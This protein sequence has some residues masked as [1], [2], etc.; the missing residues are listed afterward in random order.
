MQQ[1]RGE[2]CRLELG[3]RTRGPERAV[4]RVQLRPQCPPGQACVPELA[5]THDVVDRPKAIEGAA[6]RLI[7]RARRDSNPQPSDP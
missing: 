2:K 6:N 5:M 7:L 3:Q 1:L 4:L